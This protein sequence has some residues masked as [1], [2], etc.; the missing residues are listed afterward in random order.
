MGQ[1]DSNAVQLVQPHR[2]ARGGDIRGD[3]AVEGGDAGGVEGDQLAGLV[4][5]GEQL[6]GLHQ[7]RQRAVAYTLHL[8]ATFE[9]RISQFRFKG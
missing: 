6:E 4:I 1:L 2:E 9:T 8:Q 7:P 3:G 5:L